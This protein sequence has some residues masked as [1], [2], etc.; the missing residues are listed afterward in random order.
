MK[1]AACGRE[2]SQDAGFCGGCGAKITA[3]A[4]PLFDLEVGKAKAGTFDLEA[5]KASAPAPGLPTENEA[6]RPAPADVRFDLTPESR[7]QTPR[8]A[9]VSAAPPG[10][11]APPKF[12]FLVCIGGPDAGKRMAIG[13]QETTLGRSVQCG[14]LSEDP[15]VGPQQAALSAQNGQIQFRSLAPV[16]IFVNGMALAN[17]ILAPGSQM[18]IGRSF[19]QIEAAP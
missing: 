14:L 12:L 4:S 3:V 7:A 13:E 5:G 8:P 18:R 17:G 1:C 19:W 10:Q 15:D 11:T 9:P 6:P 16:P 2:N